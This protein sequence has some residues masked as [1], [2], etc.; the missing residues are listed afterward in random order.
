MKRA[1]PA[2][3]SLAF[4]ASFA[5]GCG[6]DGGRPSVDEI[7]AGLQE[8]LGGSLGGDLSDEMATCV[9]EAFHDSDLSDEA[10]RAI[11]DGDEDYDASGED[12]EALQSVSSES[13]AECAQ[14]ELPDME[15]PSEEPA[16]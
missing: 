11:A 10:L 14:A 2:L 9:A 8:N 3:A 6:G 1:L 7:A 4:V 16:E 13:I 15:L 5:A 12:E